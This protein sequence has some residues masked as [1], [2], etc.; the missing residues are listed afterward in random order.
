MATLVED[1]NQERISV[2]AK[3][4]KECNKLSSNSVVLVTV[5]GCCCFGLFREMLTM[6]HFISQWKRSRWNK[7]R[8]CWL[9]WAGYHEITAKMTFLLEF[10]VQTNKRID[11]VDVGEC[12]NMVRLVVRKWPLSHLNAIIILLISIMNLSLV[13]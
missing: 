7:W 2:S 1:F 4:K 12:L 10:S 8:C 9:T 5:V 13:Y 11:G 6:Q 3:W